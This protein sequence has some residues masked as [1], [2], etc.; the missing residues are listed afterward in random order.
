MNDIISMAEAIIN[1]EA[2]TNTNSQVSDNQLTTDSQSVQTPNTTDSGANEVAWKGIKGCKSFKTPVTITEAIEAIGGDY[3]VEKR[4]LIAVDDATFKN[5][6]NNQPI[7]GITSHNIVD[8]HM[9]TAISES[10]DILGVV[11]DTYGIVQN[12][13]AFEF[14]DIITSGELG[15]NKAVIETAGILGGGKRM[16]VSAKMPNETLKDEFGIDNYILCT[17][18][19]DGSGAV[20]ACFTPIRVIC[21]NTLN[22]ALK[23]AQNKVAIRHSLNVSQRVDW[24]RQENI[25]NAT[26]VLKM[27]EHFTEEF[28]NDLRFLNSVKIGANFD[29]EKFAC[30]I[31]A[32][33]AEMKL[34]EQASYKYDKVDEI[35]QRK[36][37]QIT[38]L[39]NTIDKGVGQTEYRG[40]KLWLYNGLT[41]YFSNVKNYRDN[42]QKF[43]NLTSGADYRKVQK[44]HDMLI[45]A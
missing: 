4:H 26:M 6:E 16:Y 8:G 22:Q 21:Q 24:Q 18:S 10:G 23:E 38:T 37:N 2:N 5:I 45:M 12:K 7:S 19:H 33:S 34:I 44:A 39:I 43:L 32:D 17:N 36:K 42:E 28:M 14:M 15:G 40:T 11:S 9:A 30:Q 35:S 25:N 13:S 3:N 41:T 29:V 27:Q 20:I 31:F 1:Q